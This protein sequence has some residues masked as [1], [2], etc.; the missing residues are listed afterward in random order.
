MNKFLKA[1]QLVDDELSCPKNCNICEEG[2]MQYLPKEIDFLSR[3]INIPKEKIAN[4]H[5]I[6]GH[7]VWAMMSNEKHCPFYKFGKCINRN[8]R[9]L[10]CRSYP[11]LPILKRGRLDIRLDEKCPL[12]KRNM[13]PKGFLNRAKDAWEIANPPIW[14]LKIYKEIK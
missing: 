7:L 4:L 1:Y 14:W 12:V 5:E 3:R 6:N 2:A 11:A 13:V 8:A 10:D 9:A